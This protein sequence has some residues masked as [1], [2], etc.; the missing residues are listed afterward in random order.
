MSCVPL[1]RQRSNVQVVDKQLVNV[2]TTYVFMS[3]QPNSIGFLQQT[4]SW[5]GR[6]PVDTTCM[7]S[8]IAKWIP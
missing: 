3:F 5:M 1:D 2:G 8:I 7:S 4:F 6:Q